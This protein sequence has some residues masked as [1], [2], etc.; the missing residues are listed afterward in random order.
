MDTPTAAGPWSRTAVHN[1]DMLDLGGLEGFGDEENQPPADFQGLFCPTPGPHKASVVKAARAATGHHH[2]AAA[3]IQSKVR[4][5]EPRRKC[6][7]RSPR[8][9]CVATITRASFHVP[10]PSSV[11]ISAGASLRRGAGAGATAAGAA[12]GMRHTR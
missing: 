4:D 2:T 7:E 11:L 10:T 8:S 1:L 5:T 3:A 6:C 9:M 12:G